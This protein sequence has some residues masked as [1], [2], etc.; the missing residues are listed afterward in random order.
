MST[1]DPLRIGLSLIAENNARMKPIDAKPDISELVLLEDQLLGIAMIMR[2]LGLQADRQRCSL[3]RNEEDA[4]GYQMI[5]LCVGEHV[6]GW[7]GERNWDGIQARRLEGIFP[8]SIFKLDDEQPS[9]IRT[10]PANISHDED[11]RRMKEIAGQY[12]KWH[13]WMDE[14]VAE[15]SQLELDEGTQRVATKKPSARL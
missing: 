5:G 14:K 2:S 8:Q 15:L 9:F 11:A 3:F 1:H 12:P 7:D 10:V 13:R 4:S 6:L